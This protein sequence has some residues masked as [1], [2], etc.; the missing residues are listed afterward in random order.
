MLR[1]TNRLGTILWAVTV[2]AHIPTGSFAASSDQ[3][4]IPY[5]S[6]VQ[7]V[8]E[9]DVLNARANATAKSADIGD[10]YNG[11]L[12]EV[13]AQNASGKWSRV[14]VG[15]RTAWVSTKYLSPRPKNSFQF[16]CGGTEPF[17]SLTFDSA[18]PAI[19]DP[20]G[21][22][23]KTLDISTLSLNMAQRYWRLSYQGPFFNGEILAHECS[24]GMSDRTY[25]WLFRGLVD[26]TPIAGCCSLN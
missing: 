2:L 14:N 7:G 15:E 11:D 18:N 23:G 21:G 20:L 3:L 26:Q 6:H 5:V 16:V 19:F 13:T 22:P 12:V 17:W 24:D 1:D 10:L 9:G 8:P 25:G 4:F